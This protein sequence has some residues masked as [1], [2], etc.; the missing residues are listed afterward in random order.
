MDLKPFISNTNVWRKHFEKTSKTGYNDN[1]RYHVIQ[2]GSGFPF[3]NIITV[4]PTKQAED[5]AKSEIIEINKSK[6][7][8]ARKYKKKSKP[9]QNQNTFGLRKGNIKAKSTLKSTK[10]KTNVLKKRI[11]SHKRTK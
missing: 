3:N 5:I 11:L 9:K 2:E 1:K 8:E 10:L 6:V 4:S 7:Q